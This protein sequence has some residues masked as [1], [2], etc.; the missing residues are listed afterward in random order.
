MPCAIIDTSNGPLW[1]QSAQG[2]NLANHV[3]G[4]ESREVATGSRVREV[5]TWCH[6]AIV[7][8]GMVSQGFQLSAVQC[9]QAQ[10]LI[11]SVVV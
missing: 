1:S 7:G 5:A 11:S 3:V 2:V 4:K 6:Q 10:G 8:H 9:Q